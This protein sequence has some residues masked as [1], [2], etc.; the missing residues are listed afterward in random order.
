MTRRLLILGSPG[1][2][3]SSLARLLAEGRPGDLVHLDDLYWGAGWTRPTDEDWVRRLGELVTREAWIID[4]NYQ[5]S[6][7]VRAAHAEAAVVLDVAPWLC[8]LRIL[9]RSWMIRRGDRAALPRAVRDGPAARPSYDLRRLLWM[10]LAFRKASFW[11]LLEQ[12]AAD[13][14]VTEVRVGG[15]GA[16]RRVAVLRRDA[17]ARGLVIYVAGTVTPSGRH[18]SG[19]A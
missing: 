19:R 6:L 12:L 5:P 11:P 10:V 1:S 9:R 17:A 7:A 18:T 3:K 13:H 14:V 15:P 8:A 16:R 2:G 4:G